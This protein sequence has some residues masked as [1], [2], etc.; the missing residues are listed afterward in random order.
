MI[1][2]I[3]AP[4][5]SCTHKSFISKRDNKEI[6][7]W[8]ITL[9]NELARSDF[10]RFFTFTA[11]DEAVSTAGFDSPDILA[12]HAGQPLKFEGEW[13][14]HSQKNEQGEFSD[15]KFKFRITQIILKK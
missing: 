12:K 15:P 11:S 8:Q 5:V 13:N 3:Q 6:N 1:G 4:F 14:L 9:L 10:D 7:F 2:V